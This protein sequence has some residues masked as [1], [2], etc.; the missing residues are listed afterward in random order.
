MIIFIYWTRLGTLTSYK[1][2]NCSAQHYLYKV[3]PSLFPVPY[4]HILWSGFKYFRLI[5]CKN[6]LSFISHL[7]TKINSLG[8]TDSCKYFNARNRKEI[9]LHRQLQTTYTG[10]NLLMHMATD[11]SGRASR[12]PYRSGMSGLLIITKIK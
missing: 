8:V 5:K 4:S 9:I 12:N 2:I 1:I 3:I 10:V 6:A 11:F 7:Q